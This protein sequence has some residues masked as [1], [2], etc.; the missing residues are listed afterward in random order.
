[1]GDID[2]AGSQAQPDKNQASN[3]TDERILSIQHW[4]PTVLSFRTTRNV[5]FRFTA[6]HY[7]RLGLPAV[8]QGIWVFRPYSVVS[9]TWADYLEFLVVL[10]PGGAFSQQLA[11]VAVGSAIR[12]EKPA[13]GF[14]TLDRLAA[15][16]GQ[17]A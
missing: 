13:Y 10:I 3:Y 17:A 1:M 5:N 11:N 7:A 16:R 12:I 15:G 9:P 8:E 4:S 6:G 2:Q 14:L